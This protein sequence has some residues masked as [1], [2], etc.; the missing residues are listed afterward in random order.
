ML[1]ENSTTIESLN[2]ENRTLRKKINDLE[3]NSIKD[4]ESMQRMKKELKIY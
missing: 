2:G 4:R 1:N 3:I